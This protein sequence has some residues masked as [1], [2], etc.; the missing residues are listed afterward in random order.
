MLTYIGVHS[1]TLAGLFAYD[2]CRTLRRPSVAAWECELAGGWAGPDGSSCSLDD[3]E[4][5]RIGVTARVFC[6][7]PANLHDFRYRCIRRLL[8]CGKVNR[9]QGRA[10]RKLADAEHWA[11]LVLAVRVLVGFHGWKARQRAHVRWIGLR[12]LGAR[13]AEPRGREELF[14]QG[15]PLPRFL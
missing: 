14:P 1:D 15:A 6:L 13:N 12:L 8:A 4:G 10:L 7:L 2:D 5:I 11:E 9:A 3:V